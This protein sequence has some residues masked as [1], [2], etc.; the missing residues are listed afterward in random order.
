MFDNGLVETPE[1]D[2]EV[3]SMLEDVDKIN[4][5][6]VRLQKRQADFIEDAHTIASPR[7][8]P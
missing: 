5:L 2:A 1:A 7:R 3:W 4:E 8:L 6:Q